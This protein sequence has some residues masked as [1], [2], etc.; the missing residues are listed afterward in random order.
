MRTPVIPRAVV[1]AFMTIPFAAA[2]GGGY[3][4]GVVNAGQDPWLK[5]VMYDPCMNG[6]VSASGMFS[7]QLAEDKAMARM[8]MIDA[9]EL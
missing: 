7:S 6:D 2:A 9:K 1:L 4:G 8:A 5:E 3:T